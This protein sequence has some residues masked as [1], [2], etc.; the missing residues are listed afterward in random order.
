MNF[1]FLR[2]HESR[3]IIRNVLCSKKQSV[4]SCAALNNHWHGGNAPLLTGGRM[5]VTA[6][7]LQLPGAPFGFELVRVFSPPFLDLHGIRSL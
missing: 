7:A 5:P 2:V 4:S 1:F 6:A 3:A